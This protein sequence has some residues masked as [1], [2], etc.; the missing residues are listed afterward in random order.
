MHKLIFNCQR[1]CQH[2]FIVK[3]KKNKIAGAK[4]SADLISRYE[5]LKKDFEDIFIG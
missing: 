3:N 4:I 2:L 1:H 5:A